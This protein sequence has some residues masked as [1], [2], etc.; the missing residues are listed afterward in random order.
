[1]SEIKETVS[2]TIDYIEDHLGEEITLDDIADF[3]GYSK[4]HLNRVFADAVG[5]TI[6]KYVQKRRLTEAARKLVC[7]DTSIIDIAYEANYDSQQAFTLA[8]KQL[9]AITPQIYREIGRFL[10]KQ[11]AFMI[12]TLSN[13]DLL[14]QFNT[15]L[16]HNRKWG[17][18]A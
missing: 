16:N 9:Y 12:H 1:M 7:S 15:Q 17:G 3:A 13:S 11:E 18:A 6:Y 10:P 2:K 4:Y 14:K 8:F 5:C